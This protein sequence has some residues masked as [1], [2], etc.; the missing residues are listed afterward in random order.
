MPV[1]T[2]TTPGP[3]ASAQALQCGTPGHG[4]G[5]RRRHTPG[6]TFSPRPTSRLRVGLRTA[7]DGNVRRRTALDAVV[8][9]MTTSPRWRAATSRRWPRCGRRTARS[10]SPG[11]STPSGPAACASTSPSSSRP[12]RT[13]RSRCSS[14]VTEGDRSAVHWTA[15]GTHLGLAVGRRADRRPRELRGDRPARGARRPDR[16]QRRGGGHA[17]DRPPARPGAGGRL[18]GR[19]AALLGVQREDAGRAARGCEARARAGGRRRLAPAR[20]RAAHDERLPARG[21]GRRRDAV[22]RRHPLDDARARRGGGAAGRHQPDRARP[23]G[24]R[25]SRRG[26]RPARAG[27]LPPRRPRGGGEQRAAARPTTSSTS[28]GSRPA[29]STATC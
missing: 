23:R 20:R 1:S 2:S 27:L 14:T 18:G 28:S 17:V 15:V 16:P 12:S 25:P 22:R 5:S 8:D 10:T 11:R 21:R 7:P 26:A 4:S 6:M 9:A 29:T 13:S 19:A 24:R 3:A